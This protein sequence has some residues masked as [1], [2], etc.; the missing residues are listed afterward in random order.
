MKSNKLSI[1]IW[2]G[3]SIMGLTCLLGFVAKSDMTQNLNMPVVERVENVVFVSDSNTELNDM[4]RVE[5][6]DGLIKIYHNGENYQAIYKIK[7]TETLEFQ[8]PAGEN[9]DIEFW[10]YTKV[11][12]IANI[13]VFYYGLKVLKKDTRINDQI[14]INLSFNNSPAVVLYNEDLSN[15]MSEALLR[16]DLK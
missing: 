8:T 11:E 10:D 9:I 1:L 3:L 7:D 6:M 14:K 13:N 12:N 16:S 15:A 2:F 4:Y 5:V